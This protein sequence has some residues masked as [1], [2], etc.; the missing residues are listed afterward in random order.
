MHL[1]KHLNHPLPVSL[2]ILAEENIQARVR[3][4]ILMAL[5]QNKFGYILLNTSNKS[6]AAGWLRNIIWRYVRRLI[7]VLGDVYKLTGLYEIG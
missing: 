3:A 2:S 6:E 5:I 7:S 4:V 1:K